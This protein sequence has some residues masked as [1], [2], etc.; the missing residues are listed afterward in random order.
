MTDNYDDYT[1][2]WYMIPIEDSAS[3]SGDLNEI[4]YV[5]V[6]FYEDQASTRRAMARG[7]KRFL[8]I[9][10]SPARYLKKVEIVNKQKIVL[11]TSVQIEYSVKI[12]ANSFAVD[13]Y[14][15]NLNGG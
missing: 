1:P 7:R 5:D 3:P 8:E 2:D 11:F 4:A 13:S 15:N 14:Y 12:V 6:S 9:S 10:K